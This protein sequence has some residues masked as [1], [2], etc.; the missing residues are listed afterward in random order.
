[1]NRDR[2]GD[3]SPEGSGPRRLTD[4]SL[5][6]KLDRAVPSSD[7]VAFLMA[8][9]G[10]ERG[11]VYALSRNTVMVGRVEGADV[12]LSDP[13]VSGEHAR[14]INGP[15]GFE[16]EDLDSTNG[17]FV[18]GRRVT[19]TRLRSGDRV[20][21]GTVE[22][23]FLLDR[24]I[25]ATV[26]LLP[27]G[28][29]SPAQTS[30]SMIPAIPRHPPFP[31]V[32]PP[33]MARNEDQGP[34]AAELLQKAV[35][36]YRFL[37]R[38]GIVIAGLAVAGLT[39]GVFSLL[40]VPPRPVALCEVKL[41]PQVKANPVDTTPWKPPEETVQFFVGA[42][43]AFTHPELVRTTLRRL[44]GKD[45]EKGRA[46]V[47]AGRLNLE[48]LGDHVYRATY[49]AP[50]FSSGKGAVEFLSLHLDNYVRSEVAKALRAFTAEVE[51][52]R[53][54][55]KTVDQDMTAIN[56]EK[57]KFR[58]KN[59][60]QLPE[61]AMQAHTTR[62]ELESRRADLL[63]R[64]RK[65]EADLVTEKQALDSDNPLAETK[66]RSSQV[67]RDKLATI[68]SRLAEAYSRGLADGHPDVI[69]LKQEKDRMEDLVTGEMGSETSAVDRRSNP[70][71]QALQHRVSGLQA[72]LSAARRDLGDTERSLGQMRHVVGTLPR[73]EER[74]QELNHSQEATTRLHAQ[75]FE[76]LKKAELQLN[77]ERVSAESRHEILMRPQLESGKT[78]KNLV[79]RAA[80][81]IFLG[82][83]A[84][85]VIIIAREVKR[86][87]AQGAL[88][89]EPPSVRSW[90]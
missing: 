30:S 60:F 44:D 6:A 9:S 64:V 27:P 41:L 26:A 40:V 74:L 37:R 45:P 68:N 83:L 39:A 33:G 7:A 42:E 43:R 72:Q 13:S 47:T 66:Y 25:D 84:A 56:Q 53:N 62:F 82:L 22:L 61:Q 18:G 50:M 15:Y 79:L 35:L 63:A 78:A 4:S 24:P 2:S 48:P 81:G 28:A 3:E 32:V 55:V 38:H 80:V 12:R 86:M 85:A 70:A 20:T 75:L 34:S 90:R 65:L 29:W 11:R 46:S 1:M 54:Q 16:I 77:L 52:L 57:A 69:Q 36:V 14:I 5:D 51:F 19:R 71:L 88:T 8:V 58:E 31:V 59:A 10:P 89:T 76:K 73:V 23:S 21:I 17:T 67:Y 49:K 87:L